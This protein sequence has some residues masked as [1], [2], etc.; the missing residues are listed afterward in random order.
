MRIFSFLSEAK[1]RSL[2]PLFVYKSILCQKY[3]NRRELTC[4]SSS[5]G[6]QHSKLSNFNLS[7]YTKDLLGRLYLYFGLLTRVF[8][9][10]YVKP[11]L[12]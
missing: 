12:I 6:R 8:F 5:K 1:V 9:L 4:I 10:F 11:K 3:V 2:M 7:S